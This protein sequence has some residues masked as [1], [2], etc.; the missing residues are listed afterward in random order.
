MDLFGFESIGSQTNYDWKGKARIL[1][2]QSFY[3]LSTIAQA[4]AKSL[5]WRCKTKTGEESF[6]IQF[7][8][9]RTYR[10]F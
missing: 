5:K 7:H 1:Y 4:F 6:L 2:L 3:L 10:Y 8:K 9:R